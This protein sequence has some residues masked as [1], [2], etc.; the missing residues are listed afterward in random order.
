MQRPDRIDPA[1][2]E[3]ALKQRA[4]FRLKQR[5]FCIGAPRKIPL[6]KSPRI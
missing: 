5:V 3:N 6:A 4:A 1:L 2:I